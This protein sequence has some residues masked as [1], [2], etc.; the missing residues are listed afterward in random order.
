VPDT[1]PRIDN[2]VI[3]PSFEVN[4]TGWYALASSAI[5]RVTTHYWTGLAAGQGQAT[6]T[7][8]QYGLQTAAGVADATRILASPDEVL[9]FGARVQTALASQRGRLRIEWRNSSSAVISSVTGAWFNLT[10]GVANGAGWNRL[11]LEGEVAPAGTAFVTLYIEVG[12]TS[13]N[14]SAGQNFRVDGVMASPGAAL[15][16]YV[17]GSLGTYH[18]WLGTAH[19]SASYREAIVARQT[20]ARRGMT[21]ISARLYLADQ[22][23]VLQADITSEG[24][25]GKVSMNIHNP[26]KHVLAL[27]GVD[28]SAIEPYSSYV[29]PFLVLEDV[30]GSSEAYQMGLYICTPAKHQERQAFSLYTIEGRGLTWILANSYPSAPYTAA[31]GSNPVANVRAILDN[32]GLRHAIPDTADVFSGSITWDIDSSWLDICND[33]LFADSYYSLWDD[34]AGVL[35]SRPYFELA[36]A[37]PAL[38]LYSGEGGIVTGVI[39]R[40]GVY[41]TLANQIIVMKE[42]LGGSPIR[43]IRTNNDPSSPV[44]V[45]N[46][47][48]TLPR[49]IKDSNIISVTQARTI[50]RRELEIGT[51]FTNKLKVTTLPQPD[52]EVHEVYDLAIYNS[53]GKP[54]GFGLW[55]CD[56]WEIGFT[57]KS[58]TQVH[59]LK[60]LETYGWDEVY[61]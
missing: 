51:S 41:D 23:N 10:Q 25:E 27:N 40:E 35:K 15:P 39:E 37:E 50:A 4:T 9:S 21:R 7:V 61:T 14:A 6:G 42:N 2:R 43:V 48:R 24:L 57:A 29:A 8:A 19:A 11:S 28:A 26:I 53:T 52:R 54:V 3:N 12:P 16:A 36:S 46:L 33:Q 59:H 20:Y 17:D 30:Q 60:R 49:L 1:L 31:A 22:A 47:G 44:S 34:R 58:A 38:Q 56:S 32:H 13:G 18:Y 55:W 5:S 45:P